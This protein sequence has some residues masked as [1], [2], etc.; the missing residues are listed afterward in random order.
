MICWTDNQRRISFTE[1]LYC[2]NDK[3]VI[4]YGRNGWFTQRAAR[5]Q[6]QEIYWRQTNSP[7]TEARSTEGKVPLRRDVIE[8]GGS[9]E[10]W[11]EAGGSRKRGT[12]FTGGKKLLPARWIEAPGSS[13]LGME[14]RH[15]VL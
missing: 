10:V 8:R 3:K 12:S 5:A 15:V 2:A 9:N 7:P 1:N 4:S 13:E 11:Y 14:V 6:G